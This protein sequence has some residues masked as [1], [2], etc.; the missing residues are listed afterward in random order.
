VDFTVALSRLPRPGETVSEGTLLVAHG[1]KGANQAVAARRLGA[2]VRLVGCV[3]DDPSGREVRA[4]LVAEG[5]GVDALAT[6]VG[7]ATGTA[8]IV[9][10]REGRNQI[11]VA[12]GAN[13]SLT[14]ADVE[15]RE[16]D[17]AWAEVVVCSL[18]V[19]LDAIRRALEIARGQKVTT[20][21]NPAPFPDAG[22]DFLTLADYV[23]PNEGEAARLAG[24][25]IADL[26]SA[27]KAAALVR[28]RGGG[29]AVLTL[30]A[31]GA[32]ADG[33][34]GVVHAPAFAVTAVDTTGA[35][36]AFNGALAVALGQARPLGEALRFANA[37]AALAC[38]RRGAQPSM[39]VRA[40]VE[41]LLGG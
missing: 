11:A 36:D 23:T 4:A 13:R 14:V 34:G 1:G 27:R 29:T 5:I 31:N 40:E 41:R 37:A 39:P 17:F 24:L 30:G 35:G 15:R 6:V 12:P 21:V 10:D 9:V 32:L 16:A 19:P 28:T 18:E 26:D 8:L 3:G 22:I 2:E 20:I 25:E 33:A 7:R 38:T